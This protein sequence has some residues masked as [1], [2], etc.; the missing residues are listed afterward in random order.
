METEKLTFSPAEF[1][2]VVGCSLYE[3]YEGLRQNT[4]QHFRLGRRYFIP[5]SEIDRLCNV[6]SGSDTSSKQN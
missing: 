5:R 2:E 1:A 4:I 6:D 3:V